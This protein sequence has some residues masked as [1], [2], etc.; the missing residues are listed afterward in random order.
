[1]KVREVEELI[2]RALKWGR[3]VPF[4]NISVPVLNRFLVFFFFLI[5]FD[6]AQPFPFSTCMSYFHLWFFF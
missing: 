4:Y 3:G 5:C 6:P 1:M 2:S